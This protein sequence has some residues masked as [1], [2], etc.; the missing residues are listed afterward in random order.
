[1]ATAKENKVQ[2]NLKNVHYAVLNDEATPGYATPVPVPGAVNLNLAASGEMTPFYADGIV[3][4]KSSANN[5][6]EGDLEMARFIDKMMQDIWNNQLDE[7]DKVMIEKADVEAKAFA[8]LFQIDGDANNDL[9]VLY[10]C[11]GTRPAIAAATSTETKTPTTQTSTISATPL[12]ANHFVYARTTADTPKNVR[13]NWF[14]QV[15]MPS[16]DP[17]AAKAAADSAPVQAEA[18]SEA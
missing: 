7:T 6:Y 8:L 10:N 11:T 2:L 9:Y 1:M 15:W 17:A 13:T 3:Y 14:K 5:G 16:A 4:Y 12:A 18:E